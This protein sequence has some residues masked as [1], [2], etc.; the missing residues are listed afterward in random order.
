MELEES[1]LSGEGCLVP[2]CL[3]ELGSELMGELMG[4]FDR[5]VSSAVELCLEVCVLEL[6]SVDRAPFE[7]SLSVNAVSKFISESGVS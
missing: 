5:C 7:V 3:L 6:E 2:P 1:K 4:E